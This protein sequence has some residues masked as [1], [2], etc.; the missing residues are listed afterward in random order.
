[1]TTLYVIGILLILF[2]I[3]SIGPLLAHISGY[4]IDVLEDMFNPVVIYNS[5]KFNIFGI[6]CLTIISTI[7]FLPMAL[8]FW[9]YKLCTLGR[10]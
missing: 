1:M 4:G 5:G 7:A 2:W 10:R 3:A 6:I 9:F 8:V